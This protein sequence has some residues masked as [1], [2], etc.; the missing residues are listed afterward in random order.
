M[1]SVYS[2]IDNKITDSSISNQ[3]TS[4]N[5]TMT[6]IMNVV[7]RSN[8]QCKSTVDQVE[9]TPYINTER[10]TL[11]YIVNYRNGQGWKIFSSD[12]RTPAILAEGE[13]GYFSLEEGSPSLAFWMSCVADDIAKVRNST[14]EELSFSEDEIRFNKAYW[15]GDYPRLHGDGEPIIPVGH[16]EEIIYSETVEYD[17]VDHM[18]AKWD[19]NN[20][21]NACC[22]YYVNA[23]GRA[24]A[25][26]VA[27]AGSQMLYYL[28]N[29]IGVPVNM[30]SEGYCWGDVN[31]STFFMQM[32]DFLHFFPKNLGN[33]DIYS[34]LCGKISYNTHN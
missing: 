26:C 31:N 34:Y 6:D 4:N 22:P 13:E 14:D 28:H 12:K 10:D 19:Q 30:F 24:V 27:I 18:V 3:T 20:P 5:V 9:V 16:W 25:G 29:K 33:T 1:D 21:Y 2:P 8:H 7:E 15:T 11:M 17:H 32:D 23:P